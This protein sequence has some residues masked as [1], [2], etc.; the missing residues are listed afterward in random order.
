LFFLLKGVALKG[1]ID[2][3]KWAT[4]PNKDQEPLIFTCFDFNGSSEVATA[5]HQFFVS[6]RCIYLLVFDFRE[7]VEGVNTLDYWLQSLEARNLKNPPIVIIVGTH[8]D[9]KKCTQES[10]A[11]SVQVRLH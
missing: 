5:T 8:I 9:D 11:Q 4:I 3:K 10:L 6:E 2:I 1:R 7:G